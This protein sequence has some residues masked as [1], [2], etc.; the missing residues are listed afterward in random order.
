MNVLG[1][2]KILGA[3]TSGDFTAAKTG[4]DDDSVWHSFM[5]ETIQSG[6]LGSH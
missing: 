2:A 4:G 1:H 5:A 6:G 3:R